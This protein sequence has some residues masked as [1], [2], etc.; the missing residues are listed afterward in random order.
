[1]TMRNIGLLMILV[2]FSGCSY[3]VSWEDISDPVVGRSMED[4]KKIWDEPDEIIPL[5][6]GEKEYRYKIDRSCTHYWI[7][8]PEG[9][10]IGYRYTGY[11]R[12][13]G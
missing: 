6:S 4:I 9:I 5:H 12:P 13:V 8:S 3:F 2:L 10:I 1:M 7:V 11:C